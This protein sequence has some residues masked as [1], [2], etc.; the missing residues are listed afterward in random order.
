MRKRMKKLAALC[1]CSAVLMSGTAGMNVSAATFK[2]PYLA[3]QAQSKAPDMKLY[4]HGDEMNTSAKVSAKTGDIKF[5]EN[6]KIQRFDK[7]G[8]AL[9]YV[10][11]LDNSGSVNES[12]FQEAKKQLVKMRKSL[13]K[14][15]K[16]TIYTVGAKKGT[17]EKKDV[18]GRTV[19]GKDTK[20]ESK[21]C[22]KIKNI[23]Y[24][25]SS[26]SK[27]VLYRSLNEVLKQNQSPDKRTIVL[28]ITDGEDDSVGKDIDKVK[29]SKE[30]KK[31]TVPVY[32]IILN[33]TA[34]KANEKKIKYTKNEILDE[35]N[36]HGYY[37][38][39]SIS[40]Q[41]EIVKKAFSKIDRVLQKETYVA[42]FRASSNKTKG[43]S[44][45]QITVNESAVAPIYLD[46]SKYAADKKAPEVKGDIKLSGTT[47]VTFQLAD[48]YG[49][50]I[51]DAGEKTHYQLKK[52]SGKTYNIN[53]VSATSENGNANVTLHMKEDLCKGD[54]ILECT[55]IRDESNEQNAM[56]TTTEFT[57][58]NGANPIVAMI[59]NGFRNYGWFFLVLLIIGFAGTVYKKAKKST[60]DHVEVQPEELNQSDTRRICLT[61]TD[62]YGLTKDLEW[63]V[64]GSMFIGRSDICN[65]Y[66]DDDL[67]SKQHFVID[68]TKMGCY[69]EDLESTNGTSVNGVKIT[70]RRILLDGDVITAGREKIVFHISKEQ[71]DAGTEK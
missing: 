14:E 50:N 44:K 52:A 53:S 41:T 11:L 45:L 42:N 20:K 4:M 17:A 3:E 36:C 28:M 21:D 23:K 46:Y 26:D 59:K 54:Y 67:L 33:N 5:A 37:Y 56:K 43:I 2:A 22:R 24:M 1:V 27:T 38:D 61:I 34:R 6:G 7:T 35:E 40:E 55:D 13:K 51:K 48:E 63:N 68:V 31:A 69:I 16:L 60:N 18:L 8:E 66:F 15:D 64:E 49:V 57:L 12:Q 71:S 19:R 58:H 62:R 9:R 30:V 25:A 39:C 32:G 65:I 10:V 70:S 29:T 47:D